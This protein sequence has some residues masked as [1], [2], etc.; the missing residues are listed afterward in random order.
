[1]ISVKVKGKN[2]CQDEIEYKNFET[3]LISFCN[4]FL[5]IKKMYVGKY[6]Q[7]LNKL[8]VTII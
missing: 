3:T 1:M 2:V 8:R 5:Q 7:A 6:M 4:Q